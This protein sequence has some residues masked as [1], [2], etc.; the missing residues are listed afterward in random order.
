MLVLDGNEQR[1]LANLLNLASYQ[2]DKG[3]VRECLH[4]LSGYW[5][6]YLLENVA[7]PEPANPRPV[8][9]SPEEPPA[10]TPRQSSRWDRLRR[11][12]PFRR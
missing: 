12:S 3:Y 6:T 11:F 5:P 7:E 9:S 8:V 1:K 10:E 4:G 2:V